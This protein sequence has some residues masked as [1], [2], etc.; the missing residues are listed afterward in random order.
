VSYLARQS[1]PA[2]H[3][4]KWGLLQLEKGALPLLNSH[5]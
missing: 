5:R 4:S 3:D 1:P 2:F